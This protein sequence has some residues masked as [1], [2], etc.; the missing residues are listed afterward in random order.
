MPDAETVIRE[1]CAKLGWALR[2]LPVIPGENGY[3]E[4]RPTAPYDRVVL[5]AEIPRSARPG[6]DPWDALYQCC[7]QLTD[8]EAMA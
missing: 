6:Y 7:A 3:V 5:R 8:P 4:V 2:E 1:V